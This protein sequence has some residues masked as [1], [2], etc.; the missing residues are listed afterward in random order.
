MIK[1]YDLNLVFLK[2]SRKSH[3]SKIHLARDA[4]KSS[5][6]PFPSLP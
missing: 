3:A 4:I 1:H 6:I 2:C 5:F